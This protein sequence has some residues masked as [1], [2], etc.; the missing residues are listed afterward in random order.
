MAVNADA[1]ATR[2]ALPDLQ[3]LLYNLDGAAGLS[4]GPSC[5]SGSAFPLAVRLTV[6]IRGAAAVQNVR[7]RV[8]GFLSDANHYDRVPLLNSAFVTGPGIVVVVGP[9]QVIPPRR[10]T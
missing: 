8:D 6:D 10:K 9:E 3:F 4:H 1:A 2:R 5:T 7:R